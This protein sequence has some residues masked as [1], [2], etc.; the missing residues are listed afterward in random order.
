MALAQVSTKTIRK[1]NLVIE[2]IPEIPS[3][4]ID[5]LRPFQNV[6]SAYFCDWLLDDQ[7]ILIITRFGDVGQ[8]HKIEMPLGM[9]HQLTF[10]SEPVSGGY[11]C[12]DQRQPYFLFSKDTLGNEIDQIYKYNYLTGKHAMLTDGRSKFSDVVWSNRGDR[13][14]FSST[15]RNETDWDVYIGTLAGKSSFMRLTEKEG[16]WDPVDYST[17]DSKLLVRHYVSATESYYYILEIKSKKLTPLSPLDKK[18]SYGVARWDKKGKGIYVISDQFSD[19]RQ[20]LYYDLATSRFDTIT[21][22]IPW[23]IE[24]FRISPSGDTIAFISNENGYSVLYLMDTRTRSKSIIKLPVG[25]VFGINFKPDGSKL[26]LVL[27]NVK[28]PSDVYVIDLKDKKIIRWT[29]GETVG[30]DTSSF[31]I[32]QNF[33]YPTFDRVNGKPRKIPAFIYR[34][35]K[36]KPPYPVIIELHG[37]PAGQDVPYFSPL[38]QYYIERMG[39]AIIIPN[40]RG[41]S[42]YGREFLMLDD[43]CLRENAIRD[44]GA[45]LDWIDKDPDLDARRVAVTG[46]SYG[47]YMVL[48]CMVNYSN[49]LA[50][51]IDF[52]GIS[53]FVTFLEN[54]GKYRQDL[55]RVEYG[56]ER[57]PVMREFLNKISP[58]TNAHKIKKPLFVVQGKNDPR[59]PVTEAEQIVKAVRNN[60]VEVWYLLAEDEGHGFGKKPNRDYYNQ[61]K[62]LFLEKFLLKK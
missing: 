30:I 43:G 23:D 42:G 4:I 33:E 6:R 1:G 25:Q 14:A 11:V 57:D 41:S 61:A 5:Q 37:G 13:F 54:T 45:L 32:P 38:T 35:K 47:G 3:S 15:T 48:A 2:N 59:V 8:L 17:D 55:R 31:V 52:C 24:T 58:L 16:S 26:A 51:G 19:F 62:I 46:G 56:D 12:P 60:E 36:G 40:F 21:K 39:A 29:E 10:F 53:N 49:R 50:C 28:S 44:I 22:S 7:G 20:L 27:N 18:A 34:P 9:R